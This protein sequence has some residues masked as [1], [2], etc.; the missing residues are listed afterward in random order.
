VDRSNPRQYDNFSFDFPSVQLQPDG[1][2][3]AY[4]TP[5]GGLVPVARRKSGFLGIEEIDLLPTSELIIRQPHGSLT[6]LLRVVE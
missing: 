4:R 2:T 6:V 3:F 5:D 1:R